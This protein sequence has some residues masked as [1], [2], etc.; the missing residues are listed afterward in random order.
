MKAFDLYK[1][2]CPVCGK[3]FE[4]GRKYAYKREHRHNNFYYF[5]SWHCLRE[6]EK[7]VGWTNE[8]IDCS[9]LSRFRLDGIR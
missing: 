9:S 7:K 2:K 3:K 1:R 4:S 6:Y 5:C 8:D